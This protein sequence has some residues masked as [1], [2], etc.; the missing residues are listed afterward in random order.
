MQDSGKGIPKDELE[1]IFDPFYT[2]TH[3][4]LGL[5]LYIAERLIYKHGGRIQAESEE[6]SG[7][8]F[9]VEL[10]YKVVDNYSSNKPLTEVA[11]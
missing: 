4:S 5:G 10:P 2:S 11:E 6:G 3:E 8:L 7:S 1:K 9:M